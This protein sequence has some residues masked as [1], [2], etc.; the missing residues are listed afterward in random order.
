MRPAVLAELGSAE[1]RGG[2]F[3][4]GLEHLRAAFSSLPPD[5]ERRAGI[6][7]DQI[8]A[9]FATGGMESALSVLS[10]SLAEVDASM[11]LQLEADVAMLAWL[12]GADQDLDLSRR[13]D[14][15]GETRAERTI[16]CAALAG[17]VGAGRLPG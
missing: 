1:V 7:R 4:E 10:S 5:D 8:L 11:G 12:S 14:L 15:R 13:T 2:N 3:S 6:H 9:A 17:A 16:L